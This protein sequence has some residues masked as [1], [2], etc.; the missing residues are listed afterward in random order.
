MFFQD[1]RQIMSEERSKLLQALEKERRLLTVEK[2]KLIVQKR[3]HG[4]EC[5]DENDQHNNKCNNN[6]S[7]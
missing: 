4:N 6:V 2:A 5:L 1:Q 7:I 3:L